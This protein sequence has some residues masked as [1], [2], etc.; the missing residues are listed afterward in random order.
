MPVSVVGR[1]AARGVSAARVRADARHL[2]T[3]LAEDHAELTI[4][5]VDDAEMQRLN[6]D[7]RG[8]DK[9][10]DVL[11]FALR[12]GRRAPGDE[13]VLGDVVISLDTAVRQ[14]GAHAVPVAREV[15]TLLIHGV[16]HLLGYDHERSAAEAQRMRAMERYLF[17]C[18]DRQGMQAGRG[19]AKKPTL[20]RSA[21]GSRSR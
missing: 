4:S 8:T 3:T 12:E 10:T 18:L 1:A 15:R 11:A 14:A 19:D 5:L 2:L 16:L 7:Y 20:R 6:R 13:A 17:G 9:P 21:R